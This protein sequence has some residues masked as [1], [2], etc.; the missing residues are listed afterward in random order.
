[1]G[2]LEEINKIDADV[3]SGL[4]QPIEKM[5]YET[6]HG[7]WLK[8]KVLLK[9]HPELEGLIEAPG[10]GG[11]PPKDAEKAVSFNTVSEEIGRNHVSVKKWV[12]MHL[13]I[14]K[15]QA[16]FDEWVKGAIQ[17]AYD[18]HTTKLIATDVGQ[19]KEDKQKEKAKFNAVMNAIKARLNSSQ[20]VMPEEAQWMMDQI[21]YMATGYRR[22]DKYLVDEHYEKARE[23]VQKNLARIEE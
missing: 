16:E 14:G 3:V 4:K 8:G 23:V 22:I 9:Y 19:T 11:R 18:K 6:Q 17:S 1:M 7:I 5:V 12:D 10:K 2:L 20:E 13:K 21:I 15:E